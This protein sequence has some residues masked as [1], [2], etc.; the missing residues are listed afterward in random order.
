MLQS[1]RCSQPGKEATSL[2]SLDLEER[3][4]VEVMEVVLK[5]Q[6]AALTIVVVQQA[7][8]VAVGRTHNLMEVVESL[9]FGV[10]EQHWLAGSRGIGYVFVRAVVAMNAELRS[11]LAMVGAHQVKSVGVECL[12]SGE[13]GKL[14]LYSATGDDCDQRAS[15]RPARAQHVYWKSALRMS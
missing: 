2:L 7:Q 4:S 10:A 6:S 1:P 11:R 13:I 8:R 9:V 15:A 3:A 5:S 14:V 12:D